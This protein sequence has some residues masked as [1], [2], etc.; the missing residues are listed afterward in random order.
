MNI[1]ISKY[2]DA[3]CKRLPTRKLRKRT[4]KE[5]SEHFEDISDDYKE[6]GVPEDEAVSLAIEKMGDPNKLHKQLKN[7]HKGLVWYA[8]IRAVLIAYLLFL[9]I[10]TLIPSLWNEFDDLYYSRSAEEYEEYIVEQYNEGYPIEYL[11]SFERAG[12]TYRLYTSVL[13]ESAGELRFRAYYIESVEVFGKSFPDRFLE[14]G[15]GQSDANVF[16][17][18]SDKERRGDGQTNAYIIFKELEAIKYFSVTFKPSRDLEAEGK[19]AFESELYKVPDEG[20]MIIV[21]APAGYY[22][23]NYTYYDESKNVIAPSKDSESLFSRDCAG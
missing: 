4:Y 17:T 1:E 12:R 13:P 8:R 20:E 15:V 6:Q 19:E 7:A 5:L 9:I 23:N 22:W 14:S 21:D 2:L 18:F 10:F 11:V 16:L 3:V